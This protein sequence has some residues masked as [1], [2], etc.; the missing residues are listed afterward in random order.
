MACIDSYEEGSGV[1]YTLCDD[2]NPAWRGI[3]TSYDVLNPCM[4]DCLLEAGTSLGL[5]E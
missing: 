1:E 5:C 3:R 2:P 4:E